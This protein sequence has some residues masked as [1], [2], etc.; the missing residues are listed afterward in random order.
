MT[1]P[2]SNRTTA[3]R[4]IITLT[5]Q[6]TITYAATLEPIADGAGTA[7]LTLVGLQVHVDATAMTVTSFGI[8]AVGSFSTSAPVTFVLLPGPKAFISNDLT[9]AFSVDGGGAVDYAGSL[10]ARVGGRGT[11]T[12]TILF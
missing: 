8:A 7:T 11:D 1:R 2:A 10:D 6:A 5:S 4:T 12:L 3:R 9:F